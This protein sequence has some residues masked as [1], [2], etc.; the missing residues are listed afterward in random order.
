MTDQTVLDYARPNQQKTTQQLKPISQDVD[1]KIAHTLIKMQNNGKAQGTIHSTERSLRRLA[2]YCD[3]LDPENV[4]HYIST[5]KTIKT[6]QYPIERPLDNVTRNKYIQDYDRFCKANGITWERP[7]YTVEEKVIQ[8]PTP[9]NVHAIINNASKSY[10]P[11]FTLLTEIGCNPSELADITR[12]DIDLEHA[13]IAIRGKKRH[14]SGRYRLTSQ[15]AQMLTKYMETHNTEKPFPNAHAISQVWIDTRKRTAEKLS[16]P[17][18]LKI[19]VKNLR[20]YSAARVYLKTKNSFV[21]VMQHLRHRKYDTTAH[22]IRGMAITEENEQFETK[23]T[24][25]ENDVP[26]LQDQGYEY[27]F[28]TPQGTMVFKRRKVTT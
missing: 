13:T 16:N 19:P 24:K 26:T 17:E 15:T 2:P 25:D 6:R 1:A 10:A 12:D 23:M 18:L 20:N 3:L 28:T 9:D 11:I 21:A 4:K 5:A 8:I 7:Y 14:L 27:Q 22:Y